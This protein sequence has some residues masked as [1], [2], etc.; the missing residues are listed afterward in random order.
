MTRKIV[1]ESWYTI[2]PSAAVWESYEHGSMIYILNLKGNKTP[3]L[4]SKEYVEFIDDSHQSTKEEAL[5]HLEKHIKKY[6]GED[7]VAEVMKNVRAF[8]PG[9]SPP[10]NSCEPANKGAG[11]DAKSQSI[12]SEMNLKSADIVSLAG[13][14]GSADI[15]V[16]GMES[17]QGMKSVRLTAKRSVAGVEDAIE[18]VVSVRNIGSAESPEVEVIFESIDVTAEVKAD[19][20]KRHLAAREFYRTAVEGVSHAEKIGATEVALFAAGGVNDA[21]YRG[22]T[23]WPRMGFDG[24][25]PY[26]IRAAM[27]DSLK[28]ARTVLELHSTRE[29][30]AWWRENG[31]GVAMSI[32][33]SAPDS[34][35]MRVFQ[36]FANRIS[37]RS[38]MPAGAGDGWLSP[39][40]EAEIDAVWEE[41]WAEGFLAAAREDTAG[42]TVEE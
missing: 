3:V 12:I 19:P 36:K 7:A 34:P 40:D 16:I 21:E 32:P 30:M 4:T 41:I 26:N 35:Q 9:V 28:A 37:R 8:C 10:D 42:D 6:R 27:P 38:E 25:I 39:S 15:S 33:V 1:K 5:A 2:G 29:G 17:P 23:I 24:R 11:F 14:T 22:H 13:A 20:A 18:T 31:R